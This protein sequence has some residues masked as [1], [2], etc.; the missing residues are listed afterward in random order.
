VIEVG[1][2]WKGNSMLELFKAVMEDEVGH[3]AVLIPAK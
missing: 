2:V 3:T 1:E